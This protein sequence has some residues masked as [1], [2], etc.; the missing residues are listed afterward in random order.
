MQVTPRA[1]KDPSSR[2]DQPQV[3]PGPGEFEGGAHAVLDEGVGESAGKSVSGLPAG[4]VG[5]HD[6]LGTEGVE[7]I[8]RVV[9]DRFEQWT[10][11][12]EPA[13]DGVEPVDAG[14][15]ARSPV[16]TARLRSWPRASAITITMTTATSAKSPIRDMTLASTTS[17]PM[18]HR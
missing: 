1:D 7:R 6:H 5:G 3:R 4:A 13:D 9:D 17:A 10:V 11:E 12:V 16:A 14:E 8:E 15:A 18:Y 2:L